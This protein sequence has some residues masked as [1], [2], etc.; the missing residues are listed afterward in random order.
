MV[1][2]LHGECAADSEPFGLR[3]QEL[4]GELGDEGRNIAQLAQA[5]ESLERR[6]LVVEQPFL[7]DVHGKLPCAALDGRRELFE[8]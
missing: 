3:L 4:T 6:Q 5:A 2:G 8:R 7:D 1:A